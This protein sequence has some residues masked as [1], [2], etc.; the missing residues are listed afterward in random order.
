[1][2]GA[3]KVP[4]TPAES[5]AMAMYKKPRLGEEEEG[6]EE[7]EKEAEQEQEQEVE[8]VGHVTEAK[9]GSWGRG[10][11]GTGGGGGRGGGADGCEGVGASGGDQGG[12]FLLRVV[13]QEGGRYQGRYRGVYLRMRE[14]LVSR[15][16]N[17]QL[18]IPPPPPPPPPVPTPP[19]PHHQPQPEAASARTRRNR[20][21]TRRNSSASGPIA[22][23]KGG[24]GGGGGGGERRWALLEGSSN[25]SRALSHALSS[26]HS[27]IGVNLVVLLLG[28]RQ[29]LF[30][31]LR[32]EYFFEYFTYIL[33]MDR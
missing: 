21:R 18:A 9:S 3:L 16:L 30:L 13:G 11:R 6:E 1:M 8:D 4:G 5:S 32:L 25:L 33:Y 31:T 19:P 12:G 15:Y 10:G 26:N 24:G 22:Q 28:Y 17:H 20:A 29:A 27:S 23:E 7:G 14:A 2:R